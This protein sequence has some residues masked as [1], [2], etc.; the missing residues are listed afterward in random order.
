MKRILSKFLFAISSAIMIVAPGCSNMSSGNISAEKPV[1]VLPEKSDNIKDF[2]AKELQKHL[3][4]V[5]GKKVEIV[6]DGKKLP[7]GTLSIYIG[8]TPVSDTK[9]LQKEEARYSIDGNAI[10]IYGEDT[11]GENIFRFKTTH[12]GTLFAVYFFLEN[13]LGIRWIEPGDWGI[14]YN[15]IQELGFQEKKFSW[16]PKLKQRNMRPDSAWRLKSSLECMPASMAYK[17]GEPDKKFKEQLIWLRRMRMGASINLNY[18]HAFI[19]WWEKYGKSHPEYFALVKETGKREP[20][21]Y[22]ARVERIKMCVSN[23]ELQKQVVDNWLEA[24]KSNPQGYETINVCENDSAGY[25]YCTECRKL[26]VEKEGEKFGTHMT[27]RYLYF[28]GEILKL[29]RK[30]VPDAKAVMYAYS[31]YEKPPRSEKVPDGLILGV[32]P[33]CLEENGKLDEFYKQWQAIG[34]KDIFLRPN[35]NSLNPGLPIGY[36]EKMFDSFKNG[37]K[38]G[39]MGTDYDSLHGFWEISGLGNYSVARGNIYPDRDFDYWQDEYCATFG[40]AKENIKEYY[41]Y[42]RKIWNNKIYP[43]RDKIIEIGKYGNFRR[44]LIWKLTDFFSLKDFDATDAILA[45][46]SSKNLDENTMKRIARIK[47]ANKHSRLIMEAILT[48]ADKKSSLEQRLASARKLLK[49]REKNRDNIDYCWPLLFE[50]E[51]EFGDISGIIWAEKFGTDLDPVGSNSLKWHFK[52]DEK[53]EGLSQKWQDTKWEEINKTWTPIVTTRSWENQPQM[54][55]EL[56]EKLKHYDGIGWYATR[57][58]IDKDLKGKKLYLLFGAVDESCWIYVN[59]KKAGERLFKNDD[60]WKKSF[61]I[62]IDQEVDNS[63]EWQDIT[64][65]VED[66]AGMGGIWKPVSLTVG[67]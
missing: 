38:N 27:D 32:V 14:V 57:I 16:I 43:E 12:T 26:D 54:S 22:G 23:K 9:P 15:P 53:N 28:S 62:R 5:S 49:F 17:S 31:V 6:K 47:L 61:T 18:G 3:E 65:R 58:K 36:D 11:P 39:I 48:F 21:A 46:A 1:I 2:A 8:K 37:I 30:E 64:V 56:R 67:K 24:R 55:G 41:T 20:Y 40:A 50:I 60:D 66:K 7:D 10:Y 51:K 63:K 45:E 44:G 25:C 34:A 13:E 59:G 4:L 35:D 19:T 52:I 33:S 42:W 29:A